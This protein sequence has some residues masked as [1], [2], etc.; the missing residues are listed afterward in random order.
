MSCS[1]TGYFFGDSF[2]HFRIDLHILTFATKE[3]KSHREPRTSESTLSILGTF[4]SSNDR[5]I[6]HSLPPPELNLDSSLSTY[7][8]CIL[9]QEARFSRWFEHCLAGCPDS[10]EITRALLRTDNIPPTWILTKREGSTDSTKGPC[11]RSSAEAG[12][13]G[14]GCC[15]WRQEHCR[16]P[17]PEG[18]RAA[19]SCD[20]ASL[21]SSVSLGCAW[22]LQEKRCLLVSQH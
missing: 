3:E 4:L 8:A 14:R 5:L 17:L 18:L 11:K 7:W 10:S 16:E 2:L 12:F 1:A 13:K 9:G 15:L 19:D 20:N 21:P 6:F 22:I